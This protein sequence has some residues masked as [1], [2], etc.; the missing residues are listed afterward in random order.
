MNGQIHHGLVT[1]SEVVLYDK[2]SHSKVLH[3]E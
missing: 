3:S 1:G 2:S